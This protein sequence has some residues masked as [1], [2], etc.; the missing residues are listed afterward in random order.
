MNE[1]KNVN[2]LDMNSTVKMLNLFNIN[3]EMDQQTA[4]AFDIF[5]KNPNIPGI[6]L[7]SKGKFKGMIS[8]KNFFEIMGKPFSIELFLKRPIETISQEVES[9]SI[10]MPVDTLISEAM[11]QALA[12]PQDQLYEPLVIAFSEIHYEILDVDQL[13]LAQSKIYSKILEQLKISMNCVNNLLDN[14]GEGFLTFSED[15]LVESQ[16][17]AECINIFNADLKDKFFPDLIFQTDKKQKEYLTKLLLKILRL[18]DDRNS[19]I[20]FPLLPEE[21]CINHK[22]INIKYKIIQET[23]SNQERKK[24]MVVLT[25]ITEK[26]KLENQIE[27]ERNVLKMVVKVVVHYDDYNEC[28]REYKNFCNNLISSI[29]ENKM[30]MKNIILEI[31]RNIHTFKGNF[32]QL[33]FINVVN[34]L[35]DLETAIS[36][37]IENN[38]DVA[39][40]DFLTFMGNYD[41][42]S[43]LDEDLKVLRD[44]L[45]DK[46]FKEK[47]YISISMDKLEKIERMI[48]SLMDSDEKELILH[49]FESLTSKSFKELL[50][51]YPDYTMA[52]AEKHEKPIK[53]FVVE[54]EDIFVDQSRYSDFCK[55]LIHVFRNIIEHGIEP[56]DQRIEAGKD[57]Y[58]HI[59]CVI[60]YE[61]NNIKISI[62][63][64]GGG[65]DIETIKQVIIKREI[66]T[67][68]ELDRLSEK[69]LLNMIF[70]DNF[71]TREQ[72]SALSGRGMGLS[73]V[74]HEL[75]KIGGIF[76]VESELGKGTKFNFFLPVNNVEE[77]TDFLTI[78][79]SLFST[80]KKYFE[81]S[82]IELLHVDKFEDSGD[83]RINLKTFNSFISIKSKII[84]KVIISLEYRLVRYLLNRYFPDGIQDGDENNYMEDLVSEFLNTILGNSTQMLF[85][86]GKTIT[87]GTPCYMRSIEAI[88]RLPQSKRW[89]YNLKTTEGDFNIYMFSSN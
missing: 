8:R 65:I 9:D 21:V 68:Q 69:D 2:N 4:V 13:L 48:K 16:F 30:E 87:F 20:Y 39:R 61:N 67:R 6:V 34:Q 55:S 79:S 3:M 43:W 66:Y 24:F 83:D 56:I 84:G 50:K 22:N 89:N 44:V 15:L 23:G 42:I 60:E 53:A 45:G 35:H 52:L 32:N 1:D 64:D 75:K 41:L 5:K 74:Y 47:N 88:F 78:K 76:K 70:M 18:K 63:D 46:F 27:I 71:S 54:G 28:I 12:R 80:I 77:D 40:K 14:S 49:E 10:V 37:L 38:N 82:N 57:E 73:A 58:G 7:T 81:E 33:D 25:D 19:K 85:E 72:I 62:I 11:E 59:K 17:S 29:E 31:Y 51:R 36:K 86:N 26:R